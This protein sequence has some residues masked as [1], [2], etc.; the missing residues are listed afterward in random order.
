MVLLCER[1]AGEYYFFCDQL[2]R[3]K[4]DL[5]EQDVDFLKLH[6]EYFFEL[7]N[8][9]LKKDFSS[10][11]KFMLKIWKIAEEDYYDGKYANLISKKTQNKNLVLMCDRMVHFMVSIASRLQNI[12]QDTAM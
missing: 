9:Y 10:S 7:H 11:G 4:T 1:I 6:N 8:V 2:A 5:S 3:N 12:S